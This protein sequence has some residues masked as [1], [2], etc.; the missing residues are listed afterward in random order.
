M[1]LVGSATDGGVR[2]DYQ[3]ATYDSGPSVDFEVP[4]GQDHMFESGWFFR[5]AGDSQESVFNASTS[6]S[7]VGNVS[8]IT[9]SN[10]NGRN[11]SAQVVTTVTD[12]AGGTGAAG[13]AAH[14]LT[15]TNNSGGALT[16]H[17]F[18]MAD[19][20]LNPIVANDSA[21][22]VNPTCMRL[23]HVSDGDFGDYQAI[24]ASAYY[25]APFGSTDAGAVLGNTDLTN[26]SNTGLP[27]GPGDFT[28]AFQWAPVNVPNGASAT[29]TVNQ[30]INHT[31]CAP[32]GSIT[33]RKVAVGGDGS[34][35]FTGNVTTTNPFT[36]T[37]S[38]GSGSLNVSN[39]AAGSSYQVSETVPTGW[40]LTGASCDNGSPDAVTVVAGVTTTCTFTNTKVETPAF[41]LITIVKE[42]MPKSTQNFNFNAGPR[43]PLLNGGEGGVLSAFMLDDAAPNDN[44]AY[45]KQRSFLLPNG[46]YNFSEAPPS[47]WILKGIECTAGDG[48][49]VVVTLPGV[50]I[51]LGG[52]DV[53]C[54]FKNQLS[55]T[56]QTLKYQDNNGNGVRNAGEPVLA[57]WQITATLQPTGTPTYGPIATNSLGRANF[58]FIPA[59]AYKVCEVLPNNSWMNTQP[60]GASPCHILTLAPGQTASVHFGN[61]AVQVENAA[62][63]QELAP[64]SPYAGVTIMDS[65]PNALDGYLIDWAAW[66]DRNLLTPAE[67]PVDA[68]DTTTRMYLP[69]VVK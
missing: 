59:G 15:L 9:W 41:A 38:G 36:V 2:W 7:H 69:V 65:D 18:H 10:V 21:S 60:G 43:V 62:Q 19:F 16:F 55:A 68:P 26:F 27:F 46:T 57:G 8:T 66:V 64:F 1:R 51:T 13:L 61:K 44:D 5:L 56:I 20:D 54:T 12:Q 33:V 30:A 49:S 58:N 29:F 23:T 39:L 48:S 35:G 40:Q 52:G 45:P 14:V 25:V 17:I 50:A 32:T 37:T 47:N 63:S 53:T 24:G 22:L 31:L 6:E 3:E 34:F 42:A 28:G 4:T 11:F 67:E